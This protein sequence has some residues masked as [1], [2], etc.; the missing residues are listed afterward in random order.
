MYIGILPACVRESDLLEQGS[1]TVV[2]CHV[3]TGMA[4]S[5]RVL[6]IEL[7]SS[8]RTASALNCECVH[9][10]CPQPPSRKFFILC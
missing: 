1:Q 6:G 5:A 8:E 10:P 2:S 4:F 7:W 9:W 3:L